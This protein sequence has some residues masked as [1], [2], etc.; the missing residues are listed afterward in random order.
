MLAC[1][2]GS[3]G[4]A[5]VLLEQKPTTTAEPKCTLTNMRSMEH[6]RR[7]G[8]AGATR[9]AG[10]PEDYPY[11]VVFA[12]QLF[13]HTL[14]RFDY[15]SRSE[16]ARTG[17]KLAFGSPLAAEQPQRI[18]Q[19]FQEPVLR[20]AA[21]AHP[22]VDVRFGWRVLSATPDGDGV[23]VRACEVASGRQQ[24]FRARFVA[25]CDGGAS[26]LRESSG[27]RLEGRQAVAQQVG[28]FFRAP[29]LRARNPQGDAVFWF[30]VHPKLRGIVVAIDGRELYTFHQFASLDTDPRSLDA[31]ELVRGAIGAEVPFEVLAVNPWRA[32]LMVADRYRAGNIFLAGDAAHLLIPTGGFGMNTGLCEAA[33]LGWKLEATLAGWGGERLL[34]SYEAERRPIAVRNVAAAGENA[35]AL[36]RYPAPEALIEDSDEGE[37][38]RETIGKR[39]LQ[40]QRREFESAGVQLGYRY[41]ASPICVDDGSDAPPDDPVEYVPTARPGSRA[42]HVWLEPGVA[43]FDRFGPGFTLLRLGGSRVDIAAFAKAASLRG[44]PLRVVDVAD[45]AVRALY[46]RD[47]V[48]V[49]PDQHVAWR[50]DA[51]PEDALALIDRVRG[52]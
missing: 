22:H 51:P 24:Q 32:H 47:L 33:D 2:L 44:V 19:I 7:L 10:V 43:L 3:R 34:D 30:I 48:L 29:D 20:A 41:E 18:S 1:E 16:A 50:G 6:F 46:A 37:A 25:A 26:A 13:G 52:A 21:E 12:T 31:A 38:L 8:I 27:L 15:A 42:P 9:R 11:R 14:C 4:V 45:A 5:C 35:A 39:I 40:N 17:A 36:A 23:C 49:R 28:V